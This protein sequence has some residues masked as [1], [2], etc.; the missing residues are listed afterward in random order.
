[1][2]IHL[3]DA[4]DHIQIC[5]MTLT[6]SKNMKGSNSLIFKC[7]FKY[8]VAYQ[9]QTENPQ[10]DVNVFRNIKVT[11]HSTRFRSYDTPSK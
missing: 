6:F 5:K 3:H 11:P 1:M 4:C 9:S 2:F 8:E 7:C 10:I